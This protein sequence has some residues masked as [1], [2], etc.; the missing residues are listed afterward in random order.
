QGLDEL[1]HHHQG[2]RVPVRPEMAAQ[3]LDEHFYRSPRR[4]SSSIRPS[5]PGTPSCPGMSWSRMS[6]PSSSS[7]TRSAPRSPSGSA[8]GPYELAPQNNRSIRLTVAGGRRS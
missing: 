5:C 2:D 7:E 3:E 6:R 1:E 4:S 8:N